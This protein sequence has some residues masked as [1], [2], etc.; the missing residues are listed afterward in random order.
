MPIFEPQA[1]KFEAEHRGLYQPETES[2]VGVIVQGCV[3][4]GGNLIGNEDDSVS[5]TYD[6]RLLV[7]PFWQGV[8]NVVP[9][10]TIDGFYSSN[11]DEDDY[12]RW[13]VQNLSWDTVGEFGPNQDEL[14]IRLKFQ[15][16]VQGENAQIVRLGYYLLAQGRRLGAGGLN[17]PGPVKQQG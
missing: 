14:R 4:T 15:V 1:N 7:G 3:D 11:P 8:S 12:M 17:A 13:E 10:V 6:V 16:V 5:E 2:H 9:K